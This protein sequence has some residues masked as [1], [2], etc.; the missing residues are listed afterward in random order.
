MS[1]SLRSRYHLV[2]GLF[3]TGL[4]QSGL[5]VFPLLNEQRLMA[6]W[7]GITEHAAYASHTGLSFLDRL[8]LAW[9]E[10]TP[11]Q[12]LTSQRVERPVAG[13]AGKHLVPGGCHPARLS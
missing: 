5:I 2:L 8:C 11:V 3:I 7:L 10:V 1:R 4:I 6:S 9:L 12:S 13:K